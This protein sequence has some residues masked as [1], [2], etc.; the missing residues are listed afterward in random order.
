[1]N[2]VRAPTSLADEHE[3]PYSQKPYRF[4]MQPTLNLRPRERAGLV[5]AIVALAVALNPLN[6]Q[7]RVWFR[8]E[9]VKGVPFWLD[10]LL[11]MV[12]LMVVVW[13]AIGFLV[14]GARA[15]SLG[16]PE[17]R[18]EAWF[19]GV[20]SG[21]GLTALVIGAL[22][23][24]GAL[25]FAPHPDWPVLLANF[26]SNFYEE[27]IFRGVILGL[28][29]AVLGR[30]RAWWATIISAALFCQ[31]HLQYP[32]LLLATVFVAGVVWA[33]LTVRYRSLWPAWISHT[34]ADVLVDSLFKT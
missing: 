30:E 16:L 22:A 31:G 29:L 27:F 34:L 6:R 25:V 14:L 17:R 19:A 4:F 15:L 26:V 1:M 9:V 23:A 33:W 18:R 11:F 13:G 10:H 7:V 24:L 8:D 20:F 28:L 32:P 12:T 3:T 2:A 5:I 21:L